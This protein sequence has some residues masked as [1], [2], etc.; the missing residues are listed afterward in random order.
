MKKHFLILVLFCTG[1]SISSAQYT[2]IPDANFESALEALG[3]DDIFNDG[4]V[5][6]S[7]I[8]TLTSLD[9]SNKGLTNL[10]GI[11][12]F[13]NLEVL[14]VSDNL[15]TTLDLTSNTKLIEL[16]T[17]DNE[18]TSVN[19]QNLDKLEDLDLN[20]NL[21]TTLDVSTNIALIEINIQLNNNLTTLDLSNLTALEKFNCLRARSLS[22]VILDNNTALQT[23][24]AYDA[25]INSLDLAECPNIEVL[26]LSLNNLTTLDASNN[27]LLTRIELR[28]NPLTSLDLRTGNIQALTEIDT[29]NNPNLSCISVDDAVYATTFLSGEIDSHTV[30]SKDCSMYTYI[31]DANFEAALVDLGLDTTPNDHHILNSNVSSITS[32]NVANKNISDLTGIGVFS[33]LTQLNINENQVRELHLSPN[34]LLQ[35]LDVSENLIQILD[36]SML[37]NLVSVNVQENLLFDFNLQNGNNTNIT[38]FTATDNEDLICILIDD[39]NADNSNLSNRDVQTNLSST[40]CGTVYTVIPDSNFENGLSA[41]DD[42]AND[43]Q[44]PRLAIYNAEFIDINSRSITDV[45]GI[46]DFY[47]VE[48]IDLRRNNI[49]SIDLSNNLKIRELE[50]DDNNLTSLDVT[51]NVALQQ[52]ILND[53]D[54]SAIDLS[55]N[56]LLKEL[57]LEDNYNLAAIDVTNNVNLEELILSDT[58]ITTIDLSKNVTLID[59]EF[60]DPKVPHIDLTNN[61][62]LE[63]L[64]FDGGGELESLDITGLTELYYFYIEEGSKLNSIDFSTN[65]GLTELEFYSTNVT[66]LDLSNNLELDYVNVSEN[67]SLT[68]ITFSDQTYPVLDELYADETGLESIDVS[69]LP[70]LRRLNISDTHIRQLDVSQNFDL[71]DLYAS[72]AQLEILNAK[73]GNNSNFERFQISGNANLYCVQV[74]DV[75]YANTNFTDKDAHTNYSNDCTS[76]VVNARAFLEGP[77]DGTSF[78]MKDDLRVNNVLPTTSPYEDAATCD[79]TLFDT[80]GNT[81]IVDWVEVQLRNSDDVSEIL[82]RKSALLQRNSSIVDTD[83]TSVVT[84]NAWQGNYYVAIAHR[85]HLTVA[86]SIAQ[87]FNGNEANIDFL[88]SISVLNGTNALVDVGGAVYAIPAGDVD[89]NGQVQNSDIITITQLLGG[90]GYS[91]ADLDMN[92][93]V[94]NSD[95]NNLLNQN[96]GKGEQF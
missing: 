16:T 49:N 85:N 48:R 67:T 21:L 84:V 70:I 6:T 31:A 72:N 37:P 44:V 47:N 68:T 20:D 66:T 83:G 51:K 54:I 32:L 81:A 23:I 17:E 40:G 65:T 11:E 28:D 56:T 60:D 42:I 95:I 2:S 35:N 39:E 88:S 27:P 87:T 41:Y 78:T 90:S 74:D 43:G 89:G 76:C 57:D 1:I 50:I 34:V 46:Q 25:N 13:I 53:N 62:L 58:D 5:P 63:D 33:S 26:N 8:E 91:D 29:D 73:N 92:G 12:A 7:N 3:Y 9:V 38:S 45:T 77:F 86:T 30:F 52:L 19:I 55:Q 18:L 75:D 71:E 59:L 10:T 15:L 36:L 61:I 82:Y 94:Q 96:L 64:E 93:Q 69:N 79:V 80:T 14:D 24:T 22:T 4:Q